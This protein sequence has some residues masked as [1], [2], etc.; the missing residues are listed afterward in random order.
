MKK[1][2]K[3]IKKA[4]P[5]KKV[6]KKAAPV[7]KTVAP[8]KD[9]APITPAGKLPEQKSKEFVQETIAPV[10][11]VHV[12]HWSDMIQADAIRLREREQNK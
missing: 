10:V 7:K 11:P 6:I 12:P 8:K 4:T 9:V 3:I 5:A 2:E 1:P